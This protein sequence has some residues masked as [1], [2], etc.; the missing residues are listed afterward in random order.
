MNENV[1]EEQKQIA[2]EG[3]EVLERKLRHLKIPLNER[4]VNQLVNYFKLK[5]SLD[6]FYR[7][8]NGSIDNQQLKNFV[9]QRNNAFYSFFK[10]KI[11]RSSKVPLENRQ[12]EITA[13]YDLLVFGKDEEEYI[14]GGPESRQDG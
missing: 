12:E 2:A 3:K 4:T 7:F 8:G 13:K 9:S 6:L 14:H 10:N 5:T 1:K 11:R